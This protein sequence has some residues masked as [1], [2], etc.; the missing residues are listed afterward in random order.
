[1]PSVHTTVALL[2]GGANS[3]HDVSVR[4]A[5]D[6]VDALRGQGYVVRPVGI[7]RDGVWHAAEVD[8][9]A[10]L[11]NEHGSNSPGANGS[12]LR[13]RGPRPELWRG[14][15]VVF[16]LLHGRYGEDGTVQGA[17]ELAGLPYV[18]SGVLASALAMDKR[19]T[20]R[21]AAAA[22]VPMVDTRVVCDLRELPE[23][24]RGLPLPLFVKPN[25]AGSSVGAGL[26]DD[27]GA[28]APPV[29]VALGH[30]STAL[31]QPA[32]RGDEVSI[33]VY[34]LP[35]GRAV[36][37]GPSLVRLAGDSA[38]FD[39]DGKYGGGETRIEIPGPV[40]AGIL[41]RLRDLALLAFEAIGAE[42]LARVDFFVTADGEVLLNEI[43]TMPGL[44][45]RSHFPRLCA[46][47][48]LGYAEL[49]RML[50]ERALAVGPR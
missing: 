23:A 18:G 29:R 8:A 17:A 44:T 35:G 45:A 43:N 31:V 28:L 50:V 15:D 21:V 37:T 5:R 36:A 10:A 48:G 32:V 7:D 14:A 46:A 38:F 25:R 2:F 41:D 34:R 26:V 24:V 12:T 11:A 22:G 40:A 13:V 42:G 20:W 30:D 4:S 6:A 9:L 39:F 1:L 49:L 33:G 27:L 3:E 16:P 47:E 19:M